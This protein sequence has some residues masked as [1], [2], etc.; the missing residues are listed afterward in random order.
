MMWTPLFAQSREFPSASGQQAELERGGKITATGHLG[1]LKAT[2]AGVT[3]TQALYVY[4]LK[5]RA[6]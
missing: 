1:W 4:W 3:H 6:T 5:S 2:K